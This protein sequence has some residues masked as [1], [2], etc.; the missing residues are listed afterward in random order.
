MLKKRQ[1]SN[2]LF[3]HSCLKAGRREHIFPFAGPGMEHSGCWTHVSS[4]SSKLTSQ[5]HPE[6]ATTSHFQEKREAS[7]EAA[8]PCRASWL[9]QCQ[10]QRSKG[11]RHQQSKQNHSP[12]CF[13]ESGRIKTISLPDNM[14]NCCHLSNFNHCSDLE[15]W[16]T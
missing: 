2:T 3:S 9:T 12:R 14:G 11:H 1:C 4:E 15:Y 7:P 16:Y 6:E 8:G 13:C 5:L 10:K